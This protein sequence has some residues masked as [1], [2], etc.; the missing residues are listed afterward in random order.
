MKKEITKV[1]VKS[2]KMD[3]SYEEHHSEQNY[4]NEISVKSSQIIH[5]D[6]K[7]ALRRLTPHL[8]VMCEQL[9]MNLITSREFFEA[10]DEDPEFKGLENYFVSGIVVSGSDGAKGVTIIG[11]KLLRTGK[12][13]NLTTPF[14]T[15]S[16]E[17]EV[18]AYKY[19]DLLEPAIDLVCWEAEE[20]LFNEK[21]G[22]KQTVMEF[23]VDLSEKP[24]KKG[25][26]KVKNEIDESE[27]FD[28]ASDVDFIPIQEKEAVGF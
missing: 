19:A 18:E 11:Q 5:A 2:D 6:M 9:E 22:I 10:Y 7:E 4:S 28:S 13:L 27:S 1:S 12:T 17:G 26:K 23:E 14:I 15:F 24:K 25:K 20:Y 8:V 3:A 16:G 21:F